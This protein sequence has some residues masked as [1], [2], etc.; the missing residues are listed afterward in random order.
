MIDAKVSTTRKV[1]V[2]RLTAALAVTLLVTGTIILAAPRT[3]QAKPEFAQQ[4]GL[5]CGQ[6]HVNAAGGGKLKPFGEKFKA[7]GFKVK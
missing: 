7:N 3:A 2:S 4:T 5:P 1:T 6:C